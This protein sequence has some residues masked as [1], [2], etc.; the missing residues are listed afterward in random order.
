[1]SNPASPGIQSQAFP[2]ALLEALNHPVL[3]T[4]PSQLGS[5]SSPAYLGENMF[6]HV[7]KVSSADFNPDSGT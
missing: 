1:M 2:S 6:I 5:G 4:S 7:S 3:S